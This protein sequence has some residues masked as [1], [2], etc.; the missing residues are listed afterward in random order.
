MRIFSTISALILGFGALSAQNLDVRWHNE[1][2]DTT[3]VTEILKAASQKKFSNPGNRTA[4][5]GKQFID[6][7]YVGHTLEGSP[8][9]LTVNIDELDCTTFVETVMA[10]SFTLAEHRESWQDFLYNLRRIR[11]R[12]G[13]VNGYSSRLHYIC[14]WAMDNI[15][16]GNFV[17][18]TRDMPKCRYV[19]RSIDFMTSH[20]DKYAALSDSIEYTR[21]RSIE[22][23]YRNHRFPYIK[24]TD[25]ASKEVQAA[26]HE[27]DILAF[28]SN[29]KDLDVTHMGIA[30]K[31]EDGK[32]HALHASSTA[33]K[34]MLSETPLANFVKNNRYWIGVRIFRLKE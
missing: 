27:G 32:M 8:E 5:L 3:A 14:D 23:G 22:N 26:I 30:V 19:V 15:H 13:E 7:K 29:L 31:G 21:M 24:T 11:Y 20:R 6:T 17:D 25:L 10:L 16:R 34:V 28:V 18:A 2:S 33:G 4:W 9:I 1:Q 12:A